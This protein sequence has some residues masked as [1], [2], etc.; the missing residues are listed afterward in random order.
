MSEPIDRG[1]Q[2]HVFFDARAS[3]TSPADSLPR[4]GGKTGREP[5]LREDVQEED[6]R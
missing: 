6:L 5:I 2:V 1:P 4:L 3:W